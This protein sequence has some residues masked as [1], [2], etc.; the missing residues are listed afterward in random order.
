MAAARPH[1][2]YRVLRAGWVMA[3]AFTPTSVTAVLALPWTVLA[4][5]P[6]A[7]RGG[8]FLDPTGTGM[9]LLSR[10]RLGL[11]L[12]VLLPV[13]ATV[14]AGATAGF[15]LI[16]ATAPGAL[17]PLLVLTALL[18]AAGL[19]GALFLLPA[20]GGSAVPFGPETPPGPRWEIAGLA[21]LPGTRLT[22]LQTARRALT[23]VPPP[24]AVVVAAATTPA[25][26]EQYQRFGF[27]GGPQRRVHRVT[28]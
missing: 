15:W 1:P 2:S 13:M 3:R 5:L 14:T 23:T 27:T 4:V 28:A 21:Q 10:W 20:R 26:Y 19:T 11:D 6:G 7:L 22:A 24:G 25:Q 17:A 9:V 8:L 16:A 12:L 18:V